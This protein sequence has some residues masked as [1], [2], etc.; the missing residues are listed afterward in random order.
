MLIYCIFIDLPNFLYLLLFIYSET[1]RDKSSSDAYKLIKVPDARVPVPCSSLSPTKRSTS[2]I[3]KHYSSIISHVIWVR[4]RSGA[5]VR[6]TCRPSSKLLS[7]P[8]TI[9]ALPNISL[10][11]TLVADSRSVL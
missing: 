5:R 10:L 1:E 4:F 3:V 9:L 2:R 11:L 6:R 8:I 7:A